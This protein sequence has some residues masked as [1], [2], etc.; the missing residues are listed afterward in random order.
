MGVTNTLRV[1]YLKSNSFSLA[2]R[3]NMKLIL[4]DELLGVSKVGNL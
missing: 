3:Y 4:L 1:I 2:T